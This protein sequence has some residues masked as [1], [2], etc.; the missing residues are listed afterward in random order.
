[1]AR[2]PRIHF[3]G[4]VYHVMLRGNARQVIFQG[5]EDVRWFET[6]LSDG[7]DLCDVRVFAYCWMPNHVHMALQV[8]ETPLSKMMQGLSQRYTRWFNKTHD[9]VGHLFQGRYK[10]ILVDAQAYLMA[11][12]RYIHLNPV[13]AG[14]SAD[15]SE[16]GACSHGAY[17][18]DREA[19][20][21]LDADGG[22]R[23]F[24]ADGA[25][26][27]AG[28]RRFMGEVVDDE[29]LDLLRRGNHQ[30][31]ILGDDSFYQRAMAAS[32]EPVAPAV[33]LEALTQ[34]VAGERDVHVAAVTSGSRDRK[35]ARARAMIAML[36]VD[37]A[38]RNLQE[39]AEFFNR[40]ITTMSKQVKRLREKQV[41]YKRLNDEI[42]QLMAKITPISQA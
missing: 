31:R 22:L 41:K 25:D 29:S 34:M 20:A 12:I 17:I 2:K 32:Q 16:Y 33:D 9:R 28:Y 10:A 7:V 14:L 3:P 26:A 36:A 8:A 27:R 21:W 15:L 13:R 24:G 6:F 23:L 4:A 30:G 40:D 1:M 35:S 19:E 39:V 42:Y 18:G 5:P 38:G 37:H 11:L